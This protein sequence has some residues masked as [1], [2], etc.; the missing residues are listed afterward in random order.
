MA[1]LKYKKKGRK[2]LFSHT[3]RHSVDTTFKPI[4]HDVGA[5]QRWIAVNRNGDARH[6]GFKAW[7]HIAAV[8]N[9]GSF[10]SESPRFRAS[11]ITPPISANSWH[12]STGVTAAADPTYEQPRTAARVIAIAVIRFIVFAPA[13]GPLR[14]LLL[15]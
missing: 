11:T 3:I 10:S 7:D 9:A 1:F 4:R 13:S 5:F 15:R 14:G 2:A 6:A 8:D 12:I